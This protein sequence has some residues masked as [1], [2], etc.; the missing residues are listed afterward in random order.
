[1]FIRPPAGAETCLE[2]D[3]ALALC[4]SIRWRPRHCEVLRCLAAAYATSGR[5][6]FLRALS[7]NGR[8]SAGMRLAACISNWW[9]CALGRGHLRRAQGSRDW[10]GWCA[11]EMAREGGDCARYSMLSAGAMVSQRPEGGYS[12]T[13]RARALRG[14]WAVTAAPRTTTGSPSGGQ[15]RRASEGTVNGTVCA[16]VYVREWGV[17]S[18]LGSDGRRC[19]AVW[20]AVHGEGSCA[21]LS[22]RRR[23]RRP[24]QQQHAPANGGAAGHAGGSPG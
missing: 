11:D 23:R 10:G 17:A 16:C 15:R 7:C 4:R 24:Q 19:W 12:S 6:G 21:A 2:G 8:E 20:S 14:N 13:G 18:E 22:R 9:E 1:M 3:C 5:G